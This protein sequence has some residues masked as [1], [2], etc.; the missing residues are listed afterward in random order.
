M[1]SYP[2]N[3]PQAA[4]RIVA[5]MALSDGKL[6][7]RELNLIDRFG[8]AG[9]LSLSREQLH[10]VLRDHCQDMALYTSY[11]WAERGECLPESLHRLLAEVQD[12]L[13][14]AHVLQ[15]CGAIADADAHWSAAER[16]MIDTVRR[17]WAQE[18]RT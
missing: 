3:S 18:A 16:R 15:L 2:L 10:T 12:P 7:S 11:E 9:V 17:C 5:T 13:R 8:K 1:R 6:C 4:A 14:R